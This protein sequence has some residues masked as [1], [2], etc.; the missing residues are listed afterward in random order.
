M[1]LQFSFL[2]S[3]GKPYQFANTTQ[4]KVTVEAVSELLSVRGHKELTAVGNYYVMKVTYG[5]KLLFPLG[6]EIKLAF[7]ASLCYSDK[8]MCSD[9]PVLATFPAPE[10]RCEYLDDSVKASGEGKKLTVVYRNELR[11]TYGAP[12]P[13]DM[14]VTLYASQNNQPLSQKSNTFN[15]FEGVSFSQELS[16]DSKVTDILQ[17][18]VVVARCAATLCSVITE[19]KPNQAIEVKKI[20]C[21]K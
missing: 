8:A 19:V 7:K 13:K 16:E 20:D 3:N 18:K 15:P 12:P 1:E 21:P 2:G 9:I 4:V 10:L 17:W 11:D 5:R 6:S 14:E